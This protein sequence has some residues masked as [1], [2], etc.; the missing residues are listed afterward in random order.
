M[1]QF[2]WMMVFL[3]LVMTGA[4]RADSAESAA[5]AA[6]ILPAKPF[7][8][9]YAKTLKAM[10]ISFAIESRNEGTANV[11]KIVPKGL[12]IDNSTQE[13]AVGNARV[14]DAEVGDLNVD[15]SPE[16]Y[17]YVQGEDKG[18]TGA[19]VAFSANRKKSLSDVFLPALADDPA[20]AKGYR[21][22]DQFTIIENRLVRRFPIFD[23][24]APDDKPSRIRQ[25]SYK[26]VAGEAGWRLAVDKTD[27]F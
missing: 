11:V 3:P 17:V 26:L 6:A 18:R 25:I 8:S 10:G 7:V 9:P 2:V 14:I 5:T 23:D 20:L 27:E 24:G 16:V 4:A 12:K 13:T 22:H 1:R 15:K 19:L 21:G